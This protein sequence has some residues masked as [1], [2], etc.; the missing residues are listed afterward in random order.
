[1]SCFIKI[2]STSLWRNVIFPSTTIS[3]NM[4]NIII[5]IIKENYS[6]KSIPYCYFNPLV[7]SQALFSMC[8]NTLHTRISWMKYELSSI[9]SYNSVCLRVT[10]LNIRGT[11]ATTPPRSTLGKRN[12][13]TDESSPQKC[14]LELHSISTTHERHRSSTLYK[15]RKI[16]AIP[17][18][19][20]TIAHCQGLC[21]NLQHWIWWHLCFNCKQDHLAT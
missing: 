11:S 6:L 15:V 16:V 18:I 17:S 12:G 9:Q 14:E 1:M 4:H 20:T 5:F 3:S 2:S 21:I 7:T 13:W 19:I 8:L 10:H